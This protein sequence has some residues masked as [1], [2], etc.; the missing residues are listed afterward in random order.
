ME[1]NWE[2]AISNLLNSHTE[3]ELKQN[4]NQKPEQTAYF[5]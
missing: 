3:L 5:K 1:V 4:E 2:L